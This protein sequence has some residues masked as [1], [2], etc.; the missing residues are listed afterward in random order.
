MAM[1]I[2]ELRQLVNG[3]GLHY[4]IDPDRPALFFGATGNSG[5][6][7]FIIH[8]DAEGRFLQFRTFRYKA[9]PSGCPHLGVLLRALAEM[10]A[11]HRWIKYAWDPDYGE[12]ILYG[13]MW[14]MDGTVSFEQFGVML[15][16]LLHTI[17]GNNP[18]V[19]AIIEKGV[20]PGGRPEIL[21]TPPP[22]PSAA[23]DEA[24]R[25]VLA[26]LLDHADPDPDPNEMVV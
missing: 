4:W 14:V 1:T 21:P 25:D 10:N 7:D 19:A 2:S 5:P 8:L 16:S 18:R 6:F 23:A 20:D 26:T 13:D 15:T 11:L 22:Q 17:D 9:C 3:T 12:V 24:L